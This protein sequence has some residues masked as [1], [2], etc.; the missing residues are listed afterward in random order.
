M[1]AANKSSEGEA[2]KLASKGG[3]RP[4]AGAFCAAQ[5]PKKVVPSAVQQ[6]GVFKLRKISKSIS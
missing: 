3:E 6:L 5:M 4:Q 1:L 2:G